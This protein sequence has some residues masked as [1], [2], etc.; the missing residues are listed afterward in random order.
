M[1][2][3]LFIAH[4]VNTIKE[5]QKIPVNYGIEVDIR[6]LENELILAHDPFDSSYELFKNF[7]IFYKHKFI[8]LNIKTE[9]IEL[10]VLKLI[11]K[12]NITNYFFLDCSMS[13]INKLI[14][15][16]ENNIAIRFSDLESIE[17]VL[18][19]TNKIKYVWIDSFESLSLNYSIFQKIKKSNFIIC[20]VSPELQ[21]QPEKIEIYK[22][23][24]C[25]NNIF[26]DMICTKI[27]NINKWL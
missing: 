20:L 10:E 13:I 9:G 15:F 7:L 24:L 26:P 17:T 18:K 21:N 16:N 8:I 19:F 5:L 11:K 25:S 2:N 23:Y 1:E 22:N 14:N 12:Y 6:N 27:Y 3:I 4:R